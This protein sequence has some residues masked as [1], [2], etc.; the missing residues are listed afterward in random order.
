MKLPHRR[1]FLHLAAGAASMPAMSQVA[2]AQAYP[3]RPVR[4]VAVFAAG[5]V[6]IDILARLVGQSLSERLGQPFVVENR[7]GG[8]SNIATE[9]V[10]QGGAGRLYASD[11][12]VGHINATLYEDLNFRVPPPDCPGCRVFRGS[13]SRWS[14]RRSGKNDPEFIAYAKAYPARSPWRRPAP[15]PRPH[16]AGELFNIMAGTDMVDVPYRGGRR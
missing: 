3:S 1:N 5:W 14:I 9:S 2:W 12:R 15:G 16:V 7:P 8:G 6:E 13:L 10:V 4:I 11:G